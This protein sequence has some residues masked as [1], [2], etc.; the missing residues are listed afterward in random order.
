MLELSSYVNYRLY[1]LTYINIIN[2]FT[3]VVI[4]RHI[5][6]INYISCSFLY[7]WNNRLILNNNEKNVI[8]TFRLFRM[9]NKQHYICRKSIVKKKSMHIWVN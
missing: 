4:L 5:F 2:F 1:F 9:E 6:N 3:S 8:E 7:S